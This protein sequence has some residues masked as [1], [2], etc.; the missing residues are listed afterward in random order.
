[1]HADEIVVLDG[2]QRQRAHPRRSARPRRS[3]RPG[4]P[5]AGN[6]LGVRDRSRSAD[7]VASGA[8]PSSSRARPPGSR[9]PVEQRLPSSS[10]YA[11]VSAG[12]IGPWSRSSSIAIRRARSRMR[13]SCAATHSAP[14]RPR[15]ARGWSAGGADAV[16]PSDGRGVSRRRAPLG[17]RDRGVASRARWCPSRI[18]GDTTMR[19]SVDIDVMAPSERFREAD[20]IV[21]TSGYVRNHPA[22]RLAAPVA[23]PWRAFLPSSSTFRKGQG[24]PQLHRDPCWI[25]GAGGRPT[26]VTAPPWRGVGACSRDSFPPCSLVD[27]ASTA[28][29]T[30]G[31]T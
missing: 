1:M 11:P 17:A 10:G 13:R 16:S 9:L 19:M 14:R 25:S 2:G 27:L 20:E 7:V 22:P 18:Y 23:E 3:L 6:G 8:L 29:C 30:S 28:G 15:G 12:S 24:R 21:L 26:G 4:V 31:L 5:R